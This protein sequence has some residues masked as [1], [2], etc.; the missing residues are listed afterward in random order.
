MKKI[1]IIIIAI[2]FLLNIL[3]TNKITDDLIRIRVLANSNSDYDIKVKENISN[4]VK[5]MMGNLLVDIKDI[6]TARKVIKKNI[7][8]VGDTVK[9]SMTNVSY[10]YDINYGYN[11]FPE[12]TYNGKTYAAGDYE[13]LLIKLGKGEGNNWWCILFPPFCLLEAEESEKV[14]YSFFLTE[15]FDKILN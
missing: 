6:D 11:Y 4:N 15:L 13:S 3:S 14:E 1:L 5:N 10:D 9:E 8:K 7:N 2:P 12:K